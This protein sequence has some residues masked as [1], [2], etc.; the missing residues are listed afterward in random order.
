M[1]SS[2]VQ[3]AGITGTYPGTTEYSAPSVTDG[4]AVSLTAPATFASGGTTYGFVNGR[5]D[6]AAQPR[7]AE[8]D[9]VHDAPHTTLPCAV[10]AERCTR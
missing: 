8:S 3:G 1:N 9:H 2:P 10:H 5:C 6:G 4:T 7:G